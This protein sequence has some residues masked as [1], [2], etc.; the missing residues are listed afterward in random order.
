MNIR[1]LFACLALI[2]ITQIS[3]AQF[4]N[5]KWYFGNHAGLDFVTSPPTVLTNGM[6]NSYEACSSIADGNGNLLFYT[7]GITVWNKNHQVM[8]NGTFLLGDS[9]ATQSG[10]IVKQPGNANLYYIFTL[11]DWGGNAGLMYSIVDMSLASGNGSVTSKNVAVTTPVCEKVTAARHCNGTDVWVITHEWNSDRFFAYLLSSSGLAS[12]PVTST[13]GPLIFMMGSQPNYAAVGCLKASPDFKHLAMAT[14][15]NFLG[16]DLFDFDNATGVVSNHVN[17][18]SN[19]FAYGVEFSSDGSK[20]YTSFTDSGSGAIYQW[21]VCAGTSSAV[22]ASQYLV[23]P[24]TCGQIQRAPDGKIYIAVHGASALSAINNPNAAGS[25]CGFSLNMLSISP[26]SSRGGLPQLPLTRK[27]PNNFSFNTNCA[28]VSFSPPAPI[29]VPSSCS[30]NGFT[31][32]SVHWNFGDPSSGAANTST[33][34]TPTHTFSGSGPFTVQLVMNYSCGGGSDTIR[35]TIQLPGIPLLQVTGQTT[36]CN[37]KSTTLTATGGSSYSWN[38]GS[39]SASIV[40]TP[41]QTTNYTVTAGNGTCTA[42]KVVTV[43]VSEC[44]GIFDNDNIGMIRFFPNPVLDELK[45]ES[46]IETNL[47]ITDL[48]GRVIAQYNLEKGKTFVNT[49][50]LAAGVYFI[51]IG[52]SQGGKVGKLVKA[53]E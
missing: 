32:S 26:G 27:I 33:V 53:A 43:S 40:V 35:Q 4:E 11:D 16:F 23:T 18:M 49:A 15:F 31:L 45:F 42:S 25:A 6:L 47:L 36:V 28:Q 48:S 52:N 39:S 51:Q 22:L 38:T 17:L 37:G 41:Q 1:H 24:L 12:T 3:H 7:D 34:P 21:N 44:L 30:I 14:Y 50:E 5:T 46:E 20:L 29:G 9:S 2:S 8:A 13:V 10:M 19:D